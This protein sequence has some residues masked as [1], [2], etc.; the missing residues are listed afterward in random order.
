MTSTEINLQ[1]NEYI[2]F[3]RGFLMFLFPYVG[4]LFSYNVMFMCLK[5][6]FIY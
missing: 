3:L 6:Q 2:A 1:E 5:F 4:D